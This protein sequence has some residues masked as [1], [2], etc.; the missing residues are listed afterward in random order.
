MDYEDFDASP[1]LFRA[2]KKLVSII[3]LWVSIY[4]MQQILTLFQIIM[5]SHLF[6]IL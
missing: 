3:K 4:C 6:L 2:C 5:T 1:Q